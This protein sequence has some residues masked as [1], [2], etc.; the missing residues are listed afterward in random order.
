M[1][2]VVP[3]GLV[4]F[5][6]TVCPKCVTIKKQLKAEGKEFTE[7]KVDENQDAY[8]FLVSSGFRSVPVVFQDGV[9]V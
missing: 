4:V 3:E 7:I 8:Q 5:S 2:F 9:V 6:K 1:S